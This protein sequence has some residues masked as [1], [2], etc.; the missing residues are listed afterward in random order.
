MVIHSAEHTTEEKIIQ[1]IEPIPTK[2][3][4]RGKKNFTFA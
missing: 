2:F 3:L 4:M 1:V